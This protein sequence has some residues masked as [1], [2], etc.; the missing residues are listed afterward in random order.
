MSSRQVQIISSEQ[1]V[2]ASQQLEV[3]SLEVAMTHQSVP[4]N[5]I[6]HILACECDVNNIHEMW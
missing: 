1:V 2:L 4:V 3:A 5:L 6:L